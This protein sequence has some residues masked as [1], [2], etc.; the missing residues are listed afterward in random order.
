VREKRG[1]KKD[2][3]FK[4]LRRKKG[5]GS[6]INVVR[7]DETEKEGRGFCSGP[8]QKR[9]NA[10]KQDLST[11]SLLDTHFQKK[12]EGKAQGAQDSA[13]IVK[14]LETYSVNWGRGREGI[15]NGRRVPGPIISGNT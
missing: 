3:V 11:A 14:R 12:N 6:L 4:P 15:H 13:S 9:R 5:L 7:A 2:S 1:R 10:Q 8:S